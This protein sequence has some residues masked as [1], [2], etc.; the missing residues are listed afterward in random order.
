LRQAERQLLV[1]LGRPFVARGALQAAENAVAHLGRRLVGEG[2]RQDL[3]GVFD[4]GEQAQVA[5]GQQLRL[6][7]T[8]WRLDDEGGHL[9]RPQAGD[10]VFVEAVGR[11]RHQA[12]SFRDQLAS[13]CICVATC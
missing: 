5:L 7:G 9:E 10:P 13:A 2:Q 6:A 12:F 1:R 8:R 11:W 4:D 3:F